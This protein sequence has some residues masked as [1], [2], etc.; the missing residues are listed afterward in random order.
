M[1]DGSFLSPADA[2]LF[3]NGTFSEAQKKRFLPLCPD[4]VVELTSPS[5]PIGEVNAKMRQW[6]DN[7]AQL[8]WLIN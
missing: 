1:L 7:G 8:A 4:L 2:H 6:M 5:D 3:W